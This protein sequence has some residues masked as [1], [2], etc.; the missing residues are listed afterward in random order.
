MKNSFKIIL[1]I[2]IVILILPITSLLYISFCKY[3][4]VANE[5]FID[6][7]TYIVTTNSEDGKSPK[8][9][10]VNFYTTS[11]SESNSAIGND[12]KSGD[13]FYPMGYSYNLFRIR[14]NHTDSELKD[15]IKKYCGVNEQFLYYIKILQ[16]T[17]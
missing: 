3:S 16:R 17:Y 8:Y 13:F 12:I 2:L 1:F 10:Y 4:E 15:I 11:C 14:Y 5:N 9:F 6:K 7:F